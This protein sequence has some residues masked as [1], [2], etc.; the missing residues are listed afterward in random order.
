MIDPA[1]LIPYPFAQ[2]MKLV[3]YPA[4]I[5]GR[6]AVLVPDAGSVAPV[7]EEMLEL[8]RALDGIG[9]AAPQVGIGR[10]LFVLGLPRDRDRVFVNPEIVVRSRRTVRSE[11][12][13]LSLPDVTVDV[14]R[15]AWV[16]VR[17]WDERGEP[18]ELRARG[19]LARAIQHEMDHLNGVLCIDRIDVKRRERITRRLE[20]Q[21]NNGITTRTAP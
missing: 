3:V 9:L 20:A 16:D 10:R 14:A 17:A 12:S 5:L 2:D 7:A 15:A 6:R 1:D 18:F 21:K 11:E 19:L 4:E 13:C 8:M